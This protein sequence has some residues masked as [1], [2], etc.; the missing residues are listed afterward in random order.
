MSRKKVAMTKA[1]RESK[2]QATH[3]DSSGIPTTDNV[4]HCVSCVPHS[5]SMAITCIAMSDGRSGKKYQFNRE[6]P[7]IGILTIYF[8]VVFD[9]TCPLICEGIQY[10]YSRHYDAAKNNFF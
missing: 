6:K 9:G 2:C 4:I 7:Y 8:G 1:T 3:Q 10:C 5:V